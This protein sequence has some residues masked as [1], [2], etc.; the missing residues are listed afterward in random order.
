MPTIAQIAARILLVTQAAWM[1]APAPAQAQPTHHRHT[2]HR[3]QHHQHR[4][5]H[6]MRQPMHER[7]GSVASI[8]NGS[9]FN[10]QH[11]DT[12]RAFYN[13]SEHQGY[14]PPG[15]KKDCVSVGK[16]KVWQLGHALPDS[17]VRYRLPRPL[18]LRL[19]PPPEGHYYARVGADLLLLTQDRAK[20]VDAIENAVR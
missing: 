9:F 7:V 20:V 19:G 3:A 18:E 4:P 11:Q 6:A 17:V 15:L 8:P 12:A 14:C 10:T 2:L 13:E 16:T 1:V 5:M